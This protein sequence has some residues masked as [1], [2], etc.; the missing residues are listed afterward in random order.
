MCFVGNGFRTRRYY[1]DERIWM[2]SASGL[3]LSAVSG[4]DES[5]VESVY[6][7][8]LAGSPKNLMINRSSML[9]YILVIPVFLH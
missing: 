8:K 1:V 2:G 3:V 6:C 5:G 9:I 7:C 4:Y